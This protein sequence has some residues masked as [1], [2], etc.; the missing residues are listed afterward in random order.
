[1]TVMLRNGSNFGRTKQSFCTGLRRRLSI[2]C[3]ETAGDREAS[4]I[5]LQ[6][7][8]V[9]TLA[10]QASIHRAS[11]GQGGFQRAFAYSIHIRRTSA[12]VSPV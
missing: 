11:N 5:I 4:V 2:L 8:Q 12:T 1:M 6:R 7:R 9:S 10:K 3:S